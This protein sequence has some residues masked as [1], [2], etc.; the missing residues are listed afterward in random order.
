MAKAVD[1]SCCEVHR[2][3]PKEHRGA[4]LAEFEDIIASTLNV[5][6]SDVPPIDLIA[7][8]HSASVPCTKVGS[9]SVALAR[10]LC[11]P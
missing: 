5:I 11:G 9:V 1:R 6:V 10:K 2:Q 8:D 4:F 7:Y 3:V